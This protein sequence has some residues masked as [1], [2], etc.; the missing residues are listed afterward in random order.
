MRALPLA[1]L[2]VLCTAASSAG[3]VSGK[4]LFHGTPPKPFLLMM[5]ADPK[6]MAQHKGP[7][8]AEDVLVNPNGTLRNVLVAVK[9]GL[10][11][12][13]FDLP[14]KSAVL[15]QKGCQYHPHV[16]GVM[17][18]QEV[19]IINE[20]PTLHNVHSVSKAN[21]QFNIAQPRA[22][23]KM[24]KRFEQA[25]TFKVKCEVHPWMG[26]YIGVF[27]HP[28]FA[29]TGDDGS[30]TIRNLPPGDYTIEAWHERYGTRTLSVKVTG[31]GPA[32]ADFTYEAK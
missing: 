5:N 6:C 11:S 3:D 4:V 31:S 10:S 7:V 14:G 30:Y 19:E 12:R 18:G 22:G 28:F 32:T 24:S 15:D 21:P 20:D 25:E 17:A 8:Y 23:M 2:L 27:T 16:L 1:I 9:T 26:A 29:V 13:K